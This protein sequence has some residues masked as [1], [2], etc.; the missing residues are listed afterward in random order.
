MPRYNIHIEQDVGI[1]VITAKAVFTVEA[2]D[3]AAVE[4]IIDRM[5]EDAADDRIEAVRYPP[6]AVDP[7]CT[8]KLVLTYD[9]LDDCGVVSIAYQ[10]DGGVVMTLADYM[11]GRYPDAR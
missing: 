2:P 8:G 6:E 7:S 10:Q 1:H 3:R 9:K 5:H 4:E 11:R